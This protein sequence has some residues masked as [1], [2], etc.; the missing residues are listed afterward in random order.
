MARFPFFFKVKAKPV[1]GVLGVNQPKLSRLDLIG[2]SRSDL[3]N[4]QGSTFLET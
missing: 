4:P 1:K 3:R 2:D